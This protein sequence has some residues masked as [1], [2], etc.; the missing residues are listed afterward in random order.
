MNALNDQATGLEDSEIQQFADQVTAVF[1]RVQT[2]LQRWSR[3]NSVQTFLKNAE[4]GN[5]L[6]QCEVELDTALNLFQMNTQIAMFQSQR[7]AREITSNN[8]SELREL[9]LQVLTNTT[10]TQNIVNMQIAG[11]PAAEKIMEAGQIE[12]RSLRE[13]SH[14]PT[15]MII[16]T[17][18][19]SSPPPLPQDNQRYLQYQRGLI[20]LHRVTGIPPT[21]KL[22]NGEVTK[23]GELAV[24]GGTYNDIWSGTWLG[25][26]KVALKAL[27]TIKASDIKAQKR[28]EDEISL[29]ANLKNNHILPFYGVVTDLGQHMHM[30]SPWQENG[31]V[32][33]FV[34]SNPQA[35]RIH[36]I[37]GAAKGLEYLHSEFL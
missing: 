11:E 2:R 26:E 20:N 9:L 23:E 37:L 3:L 27:R 18:R 24:A 31:N 22:L 15:N 32:L 25:E 6:D 35:D 5:G 36:L 8:H 10:E 17:E 33:D 13:S 1:E 19:S 7:G 34:K 21:V 28:F 12:L 14:P 29:W 4:I 16:A 30:V